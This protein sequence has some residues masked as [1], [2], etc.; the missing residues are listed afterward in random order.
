MRRATLIVCGVIVLVLAALA[1]KSALVSVPAVRTA[2]GAGEFDAARA[3]ARLGRILGDQRPHP[4]DSPADDMVRAR[5]VAEL[6][7]M[8]L[9]PIVRDQFA[10][11]GFERARAVACARV[12]NVIAILGP[13]TGK[14]LLL[15]AHYDSVPVGPGASDDGI[16]VATL[17]EVASILKDR[18]LGRPVMLLFNEG[19]ELGL[20]G[21]RAFLSDPLSRNVDSLLNFEARGVNGPATMFETS[22]PNG[23]AIAVFAKAVRR[24]LASS[25]STDVARLIPNGTDVM[26]YK[27]RGWLTL[28]F[29]IVGNETRYHSPGDDLAGL[30]PRSLQHMGEQALAVASEL[31][32]G[33]PEPR[34]DRIFFDVLGRWFV[35]MP[36]PVGAVLLA[37]LLIAFAAIAWNRRA[38]MRE[39]ALLLGAIVVA[40]AAAWLAVIVVQMLFAGTW[41]RAHPEITFVAIYATALFAALAMLRTLGATARPEKLR[42][43][44]WLLFLLLGGAIA[45]IAPGAIIYFLFPPALVLAGL[46]L[47]RWWPAAEIA[48][49]LA[50]L[51]VLYVTWG[52]MLAQLEQ[53][54]SPGPLWIVAPLAS[55]MI[56][57]VLMEAQPALQAA[58]RSAV[59]A[60]AALL[61]LLGWGAAAA[62]P[63]YSH[64]HQQRFTIEHVTEFPS[65]RSS[66]SILNDGASLPAAYSNLGPWKFGELPFSERKRWIAAAPRVAGV[67]PPSLEPIEVL[68]H[69]NA[70][71]IRVRL[72]SNGF[73]RIALIAPE[74]ARIEAAGIAGFVRPISGPDS[75]GKFA[76]SCTG[77][78]CD[79]V[80][81]RL[82]QASAKP[83]DFTVI[84]SR[85]GLP[86]SAAP[87]LRARP[88]NA[89][90]QYTPDETLAVVH[91]KV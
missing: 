46:V 88:A 68:R 7:A 77:R 91:A 21:A 11:N 29:A 3:K 24:P 62:A 40:V 18:P 20:I 39:P 69:G 65:A 57:A 25:M 52:E 83:I 9:K 42:P 64:D 22:T 74:D 85:N 48:G 54:F 63:A 87:L 2:N 72:H 60:F 78:S 50:G 59:L 10:C 66:W 30:D 5:L 82:E 55:I 81:I 67:L 35:Q 47:R 17:L 44:F 79:G 75:A 41:W 36:L 80:E 16:G 14:A 23:A 33:S 49:A 56:V 12:R 90:P 71:T 1:A 26:T 76:I 53:I 38:I 19:E 27:E 58:R 89:R 31:S 43:A 73:E 61:T 15:S 8:G 45:L 86:P 32:A 28:N 37:G 51:L 4:A 34:G 70:R 6:Q 84:G 13:P